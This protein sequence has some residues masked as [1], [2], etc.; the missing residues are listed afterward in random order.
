[1]KI[2]KVKVQKRERNGSDGHNEQQA[3]NDIQEG[4]F[5]GILCIIRIATWY[6]LLCSQEGCCL[7]Y[8]HNQKKSRN[9]EQKAE[10]FLF[11]R[12]LWFFVPFL[13][14]VSTQTQ[15]ASQVAQLQRTCLPMQETQEMWVDQDPLEEEMAA[16]SSILVWRIPWIEEPGGLLSMGSQRVWHNWA[17]EHA[18]THACNPK[19]HWHKEGLDYYEEGPMER[20]PTYIFQEL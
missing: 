5:K 14:L 9:D 2:K 6:F 19:I 10:A 1:M 3:L 17:T 11:N 12:Q 20:I 13:H 18:H 15:R 7:L 16:Y 4:W 8:M